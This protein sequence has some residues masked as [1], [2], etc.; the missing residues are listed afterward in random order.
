MGKTGEEGE[1]EE[2]WPHPLFSCSLLCQGEE[3]PVP[4]AGPSLSW[5]RPARPPPG[6]GTPTSPVTGI[7]F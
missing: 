3:L 2:A 4:G 6:P 5:K 1:E 7:S